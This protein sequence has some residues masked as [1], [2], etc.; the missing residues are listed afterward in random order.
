MTLLRLIEQRK[1]AKAMLVD[2]SVYIVPWKRLTLFTLTGLDWKVDSPARCVTCVIIHT[3][4]NVTSHC[5]LATIKTIIRCRSPCRMRDEFSWYRSCWCQWIQI[6]TD[7]DKYDEN[8]VSKDVES[9]I[10]G[11][12][13]VYFQL[14]GRHDLIKLI[15]T[16]FVD[17]SSDAKWR[18]YLKTSWQFD[19]ESSTHDEFKGHLCEQLCQ[20][21][22]NC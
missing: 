7:P 12:V 16:N 1:R 5:A 17:I 10:L 15:A 2:T 18:K 6:N 14:E 13:A 21:P 4:S 20:Y 8:S 3:V 22:S 11:R 9:I 19:F